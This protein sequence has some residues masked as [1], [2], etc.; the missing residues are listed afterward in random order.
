MFLAITFSIMVFGSKLESDIY[1]LYT[2]YMIS[3]NNSITLP[4]MLGSYMFETRSNFTTVLHN[5]Y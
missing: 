5:V 1:I 3:I 4:D 2:S